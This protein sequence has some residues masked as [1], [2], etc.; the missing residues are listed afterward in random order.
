MRLCSIAEE[1]GW[2]QFHTPKNLVMALS[3]E[4]AELVEIFQWM[5]PDESGALA[6]NRAREVADEMADVAIFLVRLADVTG[7]D[8]PAAVQQKFD[9]DQQRTPGERGWVSTPSAVQGSDRRDPS[10][11]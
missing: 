1:R 8:L 6:E 9:S 2:A 11:F 7:I 5:T 4:V 10:S 3:V